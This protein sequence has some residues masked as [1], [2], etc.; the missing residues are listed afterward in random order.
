MFRLVLKQGG[1]TST[2]KGLL[3]KLGLFTKHPELLKGDKYV[4][5]STISSSVLDL[6]ITR[7]HGFPS[8]DTVTP[9]NAAQMRALCDELGF[10]GFDD[11][12]RAALGGGSSR[13]WQSVVGLRGRVDRHDIL[14]EKLQRQVQELERQLRALGQGAQD[15][16]AAT[17]GTTA[18][19]EKNQDIC[20]A[21]ADDVRQ[22]RREVEAKAVD[23][24]ALADEVRRLKAS[25]GKQFAYDPY[26]EKDSLNGIIAGLTRECGGNV[27][28]KGVVN[29]TA[30][31]VRSG[32]DY[33]E[34]HGRGS[35]PENAVDFGT[36]LVFRSANEPN[37]WICY[38]FK[39]RRV[40]PT[41]YTIRT[42]GGGNGL[43]HPKSWV[44]EV[45]ND[46]KAWSVVDRRENTTGL[47][48]CHVTCNF[49]INPVPQTSFR[50]LR[51]RQTGR[52]HQS[53]NFLCLT[54]LEVFG[55]LF[56]E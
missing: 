35:E 6:F 44:F 30:S 39:P 10:S 47:N 23:L 13:A 16:K 54:S 25:M 12:I 41:S 34:A 8:P 32:R 52:N 49:S 15:G 46:G 18:A 21:V 2:P 7:L 36:D 3:V 24:Q 29:V 51:V 42:Y 28:K 50:F 4:I 11:D 43:N 26:D 14:L 20:K 31:S 33:D 38:D 45:S 48:N 27:H 19:A 37:S 55:T 1:D 53:T 56:G 22:L 5:K 40:T 9:E 17:T